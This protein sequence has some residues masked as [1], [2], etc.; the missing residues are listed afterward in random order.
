MAHYRYSC[1]DSIAAALVALGI[2]DDV[3]DAPS[4]S[5]TANSAGVNRNSAGRTPSADLAR[6]LGTFQVSLSSRSDVADESD[7]SSDEEDMGE[8]DG[9]D[10]THVAHGEEGEEGGD[11]GNGNDPILVSDDE[12]GDS[13]CVPGNRDDPIVL[14][15]GMPLQQ[16]PNN[17][18]NQLSAP[19]MQQSSLQNA[20]QQQPH[21]TTPN[22]QRPAQMQQPPEQEI[23]EIAQ[24]MMATLSEEKRATLRN[25]VIR[26]MTE[27]QC[28][29]AL[30]AKKDPLVKYLR[31][32]ARRQAAQAAG[33]QQQLD[34][35]ISKRQDEIFDF[36]IGQLQQHAKLA[37]ALKLQASGDKVVPASSN[38]NNRF[39]GHNHRR[40]ERETTAA[41]PTPTPTKNEEEFRSSLK[42]GNSVEQQEAAAQNA[43][44]SH[45]DQ[46]NEKYMDQRRQEAEAHAEIR[47]HG[48]EHMTREEEPDQAG[49]ITAVKRKIQNDQ[50]ED[51]PAAKRNLKIPSEATDV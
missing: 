49:A 45:P 8:D 14:A 10:A 6:M 34:M 16:M 35:Q 44:G 27:Q 37:N 17:G 18:M 25:H 3:D 20:H 32:I 4:T 51:L 39:D 46:I 23:E 33:G 40:Q 26:F 24:R 21:M 2:K 42:N 50:M 41:T 38:P 47:R 28:R 36:I 43:D 9:S 12:Q 22:P 29:Q 13:G 19:R 15:G 31:V 5:G 48:S 7:D 1:I 30:E 11:S